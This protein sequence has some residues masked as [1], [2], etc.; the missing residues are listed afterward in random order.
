MNRS[1][2]Y[3]YAAVLTKET[4]GGYSVRFP[5]LDGCFTQGDTLP[6]ALRMPEWL[7]LRRRERW[8]H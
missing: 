1:N 6:E 7:R 8:I 3:T 2:Q 5:Q 4:D